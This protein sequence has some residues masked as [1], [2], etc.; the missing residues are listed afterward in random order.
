MCS[1]AFVWS[2]PPLHGCSCALLLHRHLTIIQV[3]FLLLV[4]VVVLL[5]GDMSTTETVSMGMMTL[6]G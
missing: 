5:Q 4:F 6:L 1:T 2:E 3:F